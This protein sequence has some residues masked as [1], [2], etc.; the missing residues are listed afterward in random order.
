MAGTAAAVVWANVD[1]RSYEVVA[2]PLA[3]VAA[4]AVNSSPR[5]RVVT[6]A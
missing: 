4:R 2:A 6:K 1:A 5:R 3:L